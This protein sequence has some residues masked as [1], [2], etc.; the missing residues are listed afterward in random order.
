V[1]VVLLIS[2]GLLL[3][4]FYRLQSVNPGFNSDRVMSAEVFG[5][6]TK[7]PDAPSIRRLY[8]SLLERLENAPGVVS[9]A[10]TN[11]IP[12]TSVQPG[13]TRFQIQGKMYATPEDRPTADVRVASTRYFDTLNIPVKR[14]RL[15]TE[16]DHENAAPVA[17]INESMIRQFEGRDPVGVEV[18]IDN[19]RNWATVVGVVADVKAFG[20]DKDAVAQIYLPMRQIGGLAGRV[21][22]RMNG[23]P[24]TA[25]TLIRSA[26]HGIDP[27]LPIENV[28]TLD[29]I[30]DTSIATPKLTAMLLTLFA[31]L[32]L[33][34]TLTGITGVI[35]QSVSQR[36]QE[37]GLRMALG[38]TQQN[39]LGMVIG[40]GLTLVGIG[41]AIGVVSAVGV[42]RVLRSYLYE[43]TATDPLTFGIVGV[44]FVAAG[45]LACLGPAWRAT[46]VDPMNALRAE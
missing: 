35:A 17:V 31:G 45:A 3:H 9:A 42:A 5:N 4:S 26:V 11:G 1:S 16:L 23:D 14:G 43:T 8:V 40:Q 10:V 30:K 18:S 44:A 25:A 28:R 41:L 34:V 38:A 15:F 32:A 39:V 13:Q 36:T 37:F 6:F 2:A 33:L 19:G 21:L 7:Y 22:V 29:E 27:D 46:T 24:S 20:L 12:L